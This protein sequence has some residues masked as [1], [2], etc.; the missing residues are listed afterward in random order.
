MA[1]TG[2]REDLPSAP[3]G[4]LR[5]RSG[6]FDAALAAEGSPLS[7]LPPPAAAAASELLSDG[8]EGAASREPVCGV[9]CVGT[10]PQQPA[11]VE[12]GNV[13]YKLVLK[14]ETAGE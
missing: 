4:F 3:L 8:G 12:E 10:M 9:P 6:S 7:S 14:P 1:A 5:K 13:E 11:E 2:E